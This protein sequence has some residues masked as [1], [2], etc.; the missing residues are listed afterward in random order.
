MRYSSTAMASIPDISI[1]PI[2]NYDS[3]IERLYNL[4]K[5][6]V[7]RVINFRKYLFKYEGLCGIKDHLLQSG[8]R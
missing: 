6:S 3:W 1:L 8:K 2:R 5:Y 4:I 7:A